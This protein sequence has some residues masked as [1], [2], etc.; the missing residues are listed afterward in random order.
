MTSD[1]KNLRQSSP[2]VL[3]RPPA[4]KNAR[5][6][7]RVPALRGVEGHCPAEWPAATEGLHASAQAVPSAWDA[8]P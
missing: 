4:R 8:F 6:A 1:N 3:G 2:D 5:A 7:S